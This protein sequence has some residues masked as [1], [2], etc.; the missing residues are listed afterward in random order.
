MI[1]RNVDDL[2]AMVGMMSHLESTLST[3]EVSLSAWAEL[4]LA[5]CHL[6]LEGENEALNRSDAH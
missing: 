5:K 2:L 1:K 4:A 6:R 3:P